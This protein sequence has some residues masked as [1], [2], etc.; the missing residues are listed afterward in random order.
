MGI[1][2]RRIWI[3][4]QPIIKQHCQLLQHNTH[5][6]IVGNVASHVIRWAEN[7]V[8]ESYFSDEAIERIRGDGKKLL[9]SEYAQR[10]ISENEAAVRTW[11][12]A[13]K[14]IRAACL[15][16]ISRQQL[17]DLSR[18]FA[19]NILNV[20][21]Y[22]IT[23][24]E[25][26]THAVETRIKEILSAVDPQTSIE[27]A[28]SLTTPTETDMLYKE[29]QS[30]L[31]VLKN[32]SD[33]A[34]RNHMLNFPFLFC[35]ID[36]EADVLAL[37]RQRLK[38][39]NASVI[40]QEL[41]ETE[42][43][44]NELK[45]KQKEIF[46]MTSSHELQ[47]L[48]LLMQ[49]L[50]ISRLELKN[51]WSGMH[52]Y[53][54]PFFE[55]LA[56]K[57]DASV[58]D[59]MMFYTTDDIEKLAETGEPVPKDELEAR[60]KCYLY[61]YNKGNISFYS[62]EQAQEAKIKYVDPFL[63]K[64]DVTTFTGT[65]ANKGKVIGKVRLIKVDDLR[66]LAKIAKTLTKENILVTGMTNPNMMVL[67]EKVC[68]I[69]TDEGGMACHAAIVSREFNIPCVVGC[70]IATQALRDGDEVELDAD[71]GAVRILKRV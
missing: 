64:A 42:Q 39:Q 71:T 2:Y 33:N 10:I 69:I 4:E 66:E 29:K 11:W 3:A 49:K 36:L 6:H 13:A 31:S 65:I 14:R 26:V 34:L 40:E 60:K 63:P 37:M 38:E 9:D 55:I 68:G 54:L 43:R 30:W 61:I 53:L 45:N 51:C 52:F 1:N 5:R 18:A 67:I 19:D 8:V 28:I 46:G 25:F 24:T 70:S 44:L 20:F 47:C 58:R 62:G 23:S 27:A 12:A 50:T 57:A 7:G 41:R 16:D 21:A 15:N 48:A 59:V 32:P 17:G 35:N 56:K 22:F